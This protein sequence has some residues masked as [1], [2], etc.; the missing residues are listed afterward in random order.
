MKKILLIDE[1]P[2]FRDYLTKKLSEQRFEVIQA[3]NGLD[4]G[5]KLRSEL[6]DLV[7]MDYF[8]SRKSSCYHD[9]FQD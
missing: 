3:V 4:G 9:F 1:S 2:L 7:I 5:L 8:L 6:P